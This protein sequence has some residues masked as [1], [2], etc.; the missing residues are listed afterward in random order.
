M[1]P[2]SPVTNNEQDPDRPKMEEPVVMTKARL[3]ERREHQKD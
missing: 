2:T 1:E 3:H